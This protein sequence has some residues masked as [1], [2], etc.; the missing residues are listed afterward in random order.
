MEQV[1]PRLNLRL[2]P[3]VLTRR[4]VMLFY[5]LL[6]GQALIFLQIIS[7]GVSGLRNWLLTLHDILV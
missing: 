6:G 2:T 7:N 1:T 5:Y 4:Q 3:H